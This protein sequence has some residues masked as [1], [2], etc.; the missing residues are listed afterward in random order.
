MPETT[1]EVRADIEQTRERMSGAIAELER[2]VDVTQRVRDH[3]WTAVAVAFGAGI[4]LSTS[5]TDVRAARV[6]SQATRD[7]G[8]KLGGALDGVMAALIAGATQ[9]LHSRIDGMVAD[10]V[11]SIKGESSARSSPQTERPPD[12]PMRAD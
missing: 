7:T 4:A 12:P 8:N 2:K 9:A 1:T 6:T 11:T 5:K 10:V 3:P